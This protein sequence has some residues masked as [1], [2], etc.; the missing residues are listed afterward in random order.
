MAE[1]FCAATLAANVGS[2][3]SARWIASVIDMWTEPA[4]DCCP[5]E[6]IGVT[7]IREIAIDEILEKS[8][9]LAM[10]RISLP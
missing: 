8:R 1:F 3:D 5:D 6:L 9:F 2:F 10:K 7:T 4:C